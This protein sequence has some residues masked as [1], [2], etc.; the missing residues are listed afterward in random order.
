[1]TPKLDK[2]TLLSGID[3]PIPELKVNIHQPTIREIAYIGEKD[4]FLCAETI[5]MKT[6][7]FI[8][9]AENLSEE[10]KTAISS[11]SNFELLMTMGSSNPEVKINIIKLLT[12]LFPNHMIEL[13]AR[14]I[15]LID[16]RN[17][18]NTVILDE[19]NFSVLQEV[20]K[21]IL[22][23]DSDIQKEDFNPGGELAREIAEKIKK[24]R[25]KAARLKGEKEPENS[26]FLSK[27]ISALGIG[28]N[29]L[30]INNALNLTIYQ[31]LDQ[32]E[33]FSLF[34]SYKMSVKA[35]LAG[36][37]DVE[38]IDWLKDIDKN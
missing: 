27:Y 12:L 9:R 38:P 23:L 37:K 6:E 34:T 22:C 25:E 3:I 32:M 28:A 26:G 20:V 31:L 16:R 17:P 13:E 7:N 8:L 30:N 5:T 2:L 15:M 11:M 18:K 14:F 35:Q 21:I 29:S 33:R 1:M 24:G 19:N 4:F 36:A 10:D